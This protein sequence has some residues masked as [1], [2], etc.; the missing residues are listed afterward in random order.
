MTPSAKEVIAPQCEISVGGIPLKNPFCELESVDVKISA[1]TQ[2]NSCDVTLL[3]EYDN[4]GSK[5]ANGLLSLLTAGKKVVVKL[6]YKQLKKV[7][8][9]YIN[10]VSVDFSADGVLVSFSCLDARGLLM[11]NTQWQNYENESISQIINKLLKPVKKYTE[12]IQVSVP[13]KADKEYPM[14]Q[15]DV[16]DFQYICNLAKLTNCSFCMTDMKLRFVKNIFKTAR[17]LETYTWGKDILSF[18]R[19]VELAGQLGSVKVSGNSPD[20]IEEF[21]AEAKPPSGKGKTGSQLCPEVKLKEKAINNSLVKN[22]SE[23]Q[24]FAD[25]VMFEIAMKLCTGSATVLGN[26]KLVP[27]GKVEFEGL[28]PAVDGEYYISSVEHKFSTG[29]FITVIGI[30][31]VAV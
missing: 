26:Q 28:D 27:G 24:N 11:G 4:S 12:G 10:S 31:A 25:A 22:Q 30:S 20:T 18:N 9:G 17:K 5:V 29:G 15:R 13:G 2:A 8:M 14:T 3:C 6:G 1:G 19:T 21:S 16:D 23:A 7:F